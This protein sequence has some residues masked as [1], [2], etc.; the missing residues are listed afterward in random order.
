MYPVGKSSMSKRTGDSKALQRKLRGSEDR[1]KT[2]SVLGS[3]SQK[4]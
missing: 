3:A 4:I 2:D 1:R